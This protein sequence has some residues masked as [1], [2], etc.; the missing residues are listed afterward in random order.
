MLVLIDDIMFKSEP[1]F[2]GY[3]SS[4][5]SD[6]S[7]ETLEELA[8]FLLYTDKEIELLVSDFDEAEDKSLSA[9]VLKIFTDAADAKQNIKL[10]MM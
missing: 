4:V 6:K 10:T 2:L 3:I 9:K 1:D 8:E 5:I 7:F